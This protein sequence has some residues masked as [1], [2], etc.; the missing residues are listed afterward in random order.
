MIIFKRQILW[1]GIL[2]AT[3]VIATTAQQTEQ[4]ERK[5]TFEV[6]EEVT[7]NTPLSGYNINSV[8]VALQSLREF[9][10]LMDKVT[11]AGT[12]STYME[13][14]KM[15]YDSWLDGIP[16][17][18]AWQSMS[19][20]QRDFITSIIEELGRAR[21]QWDKNFWVGRSY[22]IKPESYSMTPGLEYW[23]PAV[24]EDDAMK[25]AEALVEWRDRL[26]V[27]KLE[28]T[29][30]DLADYQKE[31]SF[32][33][34]NQREKEA[35]MQELEAKIQEKI[36]EYRQKN[37][38]SKLN[39]EN[40]LLDAQESMKEFSLML[41][42]IDFELIGLEAKIASVN[43]FKAG[44][45]ITDA[46]TLLKLD[47]ILVAT[48]V[49]LAGLLAKKKAVESAVKLPQELSNL[50]SEKQDLENLEQRSLFTDISL[51][52]VS[53]SAKGLEELLANPTMDMR[54][55]RVI[56]NKVTIFPIKRR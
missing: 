6:A 40:V 53:R 21:E 11:H 19:Q 4:V 7:F 18:R 39:D 12:I 50:W 25:M 34:Q 36:K 5:L 44:G 45:T 33:E 1:V 10:E 16:Q 56:D 14:G 47:Q 8:R 29:K 43:K 38:Y 46:S 13:R 27:E 51:G 3:M 26:A 9:P 55:A 23:F 32:R 30:K 20:G 37:L 48:E 42:S 52:N 54:P 31:K 28:K 41:R 49:E 35:K 24:S 17:T 22:P 15:S 2:A